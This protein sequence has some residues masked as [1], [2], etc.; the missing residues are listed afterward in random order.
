MSLQPFRYFNSIFVKEVLQ[1][2]NNSAGKGGKD[3]SFFPASDTRQ[4]QHCMTAHPW[5]LRM[6]QSARTRSL[7][8][9][10]LLKNIVLRSF[11]SLP[12]AFHARFQCQCCWPCP[13]PSPAGTDQDSHVP[14]GQCVVKGTR[15]RS[16]LK[17]AQLSAEKQA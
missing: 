3:F 13:P 12:A 8:G 9:A 7:P 10:S 4:A 5:K 6:A 17:R 2:Q 14:V 15:I 1:I 11:H 16:P